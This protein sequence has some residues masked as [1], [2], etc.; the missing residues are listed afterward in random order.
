MA[1]GDPGVLKRNYSAIAVETTLSSALAAQS[2][3]DANTA[4][5]VVSVAGFPSQFP[6]TLLVDPDTNKE[7]VVTVYAGIGASLSVYRGQDGTQAV[8]HLA[9]ATVRHAISAREFK[10][11][12]THISA[13]GFVSDTA[14]LNNVDTHV[15]GI[16]AGE[17]D[18][19]GTAKTQTLSN[20]TLTAP[21]FADLGFIADANG[22][23]LVILDTTASAVNEITVA[24]AAA[25][26]KPTI[27]ATG[28]DTNI[29]LNLVPK[30]TGT[31]QANGVDVVT[32]SGSQTLTNKTLTS[33]NITGSPAITLS[34][35]STATEGRIAWDATN[36]QLKVGDGTVA[37]TISPDDK[38]ATLSNKTLGTALAAGTN[39]ITGLGDPTLAQ[40]AA[41]KNY[42]DTGV[43]S[44]VVAAAASATAAA[45]SATSAATS[46]SSALTSQ[47]AAATSATS[48]AASATAAATSATS[49][50]TSA[51]AAATS[52]TAAA[53]SA[54]SASTSASSALT[55]ANSAAVSATSLSD[56]SIQISFQVFG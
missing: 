39:K 15:H 55:S 54:S 31:V 10:E 20:K 45:T 46:A 38:A 52:A 19:V 48:A 4:F 28:G 44:Q 16:V 42:V 1:A 5:I 8:A 30:G 2:Q 17:G 32:L 33:P 14:I 49:A 43:S 34:T 51:T 3:G 25:S 36:D 53:T 26:G 27:S 7:E 40:D 21:R 50:A 35:A 12:Q 56:S 11:L 6:Y 29:T 24:N 22:N 9:G 23:E 47:T 41:T 37:R 18:V 13:R